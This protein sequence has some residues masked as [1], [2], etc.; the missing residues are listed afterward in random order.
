MHRWLHTWLLDHLHSYAIV[1][2]WWA[3]YYCLTR[4]L[5]DAITMSVVGLVGGIVTGTGAIHGWKETTKMRNGNAE[6]IKAWKATVTQV[7]SYTH[8]GEVPRGE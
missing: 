3:L 5:S 2:S 6:N 7:P 1:L 4:R 8:V